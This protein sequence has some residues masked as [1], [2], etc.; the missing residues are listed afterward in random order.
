MENLPQVPLKPVIECEDENAILRELEPE[1]PYE[2][3]EPR[4]GTFAAKFWGF[5]VALL[6]FLGFGA[7]G[8]Y[9]KNLN[10]D[11][12]MID[13]KFIEQAY[14]FYSDLITGTSDSAAALGIVLTAAISILIGYLVYL[15]LVSKAASSN[16]QR[17]EAIFEAA[18]SY[19]QEKE[20][21]M[22]KVKA[23]REFFQK[24]LQTLKGARVF[25]DEFEA[26]AKRIRFFEGNDYEALS[27]PSK[28]DIKDLCV[29]KNDLEVI[30]AIKPCEKDGTVAVEIVELFEDVDKDVSQIR[31][32]IYG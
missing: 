27:A 11:P 18:K 1:E 25:G 17:A 28:E 12:S 26:R 9:L 31:R 13:M 4:S 2:V 32:R 19:V 6:V 15:A 5:V 30:V 8:A 10:L 14:G 20:P 7:V 16:L 3:D 24:A 21:F 22:H 29:L 23:L